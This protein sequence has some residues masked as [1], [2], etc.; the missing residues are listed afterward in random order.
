MFTPKTGADL[1]LDAPKTG[2]IGRLLASAALPRQ[3]VPAAAPGNRRRRRALAALGLAGMLSTGWMADP[4]WAN[5]QQGTVVAGSAVINSTSPTRIDILQSS[6]RAIIDWRSFS[7]AA[8][9]QTVFHQPGA[10]SVTLNRV[11]G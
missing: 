1:R 4:A 3:A 5:P 9:E 11:T 7:I 10:G 6:D 2:L 8:G